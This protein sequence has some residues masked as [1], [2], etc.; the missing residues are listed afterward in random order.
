MTPEEPRGPGIRRAVHVPGGRIEREIDEEI[1]FHLE[2]RISA[3]IAGGSSPD[4]ARRIAESEYGDL[5]ASR[6]ELTTVDRHRR[7]RE[8]A[9]HWADSIA[10]DLRFA[11]RALRRS[12]AYAAT[13]VFTLV[14]GVAASVA[15]FAIVNSVLLRPLPFPDADRLIG[16]WHDM[17]PIGLM[18]ANQSPTTY[19]TYESQAHT[20]DGIGV[21]E[22]RAMNVADSRG[23][24]EPARL[25]AASCTASLFRV[26]GVPALHGRVIG[27]SDDVPGA[28]PVVLISEAAWH[29]RFGSDPAII[30]RAV[31]VNGV[32]REIVGVMPAAFRFPS[33]GVQLWIPLQFDRADPPPD[34]FSY[35]GVARLRLGVTLEQAQRD[36]TNV[37]PR[38]LDLFPNFV[39]G[40]TTRMMMDQTK[41]RPVLTH[42]Q[43]D[44]T[45]GVAGTLW[46]MAI[47]AFLLLLVACVNVANL[48]LV[49]ADAR[50]RELSVREALGA[51]RGRL[52]R[53]YFS[54]SAIV[55]AAGG[56]L[57]LGV[58]WVILRELVTHGPADLPRLAEIGLDARALAVAGAISVLAALTCAA[59]PM[60]RIGRRGG[61]VGLRE[62]RG[63]TA[64][65]SQHRLRGALVVAQ[66][67]LA[68][69]VLA[70]SG[71]L[72]RSLARLRAVRLGFD[73]E[74]VATVWVSPQPGRYPRGPALVHFYSTLVDDVARLPG[75][76]GV[77]VSSRLPLIVRGINQ[78]PLYPE[79]DPEY[80]TKLPPLQLFA[81]VSG[82]YFGVM[83]IPL[84][85]GHLFA[86]PDAQRE[87][88]AVV[89]KR[90]AE[91]FWHDSTGRAALGKRFRSLPAGPWYT[92]VGV[93]G[94]TRDTALAVPPSPAVY[95][96]EIVQKDT[97][98]PQTARTMALV[99]RTAGDPA[100]IEPALRQAVHSLDP[101]LP[102]FDGRPM[103]DALRSSMAR[104][105][106]VILVLG[107]GAVLTLL[108]GAV[109]LYGVMAYLVTLRR[110]ELGIRIALGATPRGIAAA[111]TGQGL[112]LAAG[113]VLGGLG[114]FAI[115]AR[116]ISVFLRVFLFGVRPWDPVALAGAALGLIAVAALASWIPGRRA[117]RVDPAEALRAD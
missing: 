67:A 57:G 13:A 16:T 63:G 96:P 25:D 104:L 34:A 111:T 109:G 50:Q 62:S 79:D 117:G 76:V 68:L 3:L 85:A 87:G 29:A 2:S 74:K 17:P 21:Y 22:E 81:S 33:A 93:V 42:L 39:P 101:T 45:G 27:A 82:D 99:V 19:F 49:R 92:V 65:R 35:N 8:R 88:D 73:P 24:V 107:G 10:Q 113:G 9:T 105:A 55:A 71:L 20:I 6:R 95:F 7:R 23:G 90:T 38:I 80:A 53:Y 70:S 12:P 1:A 26:L 32:R 37:L 44:V 4:E 40:I 64:S 41:P 91:I 11:A 48:T 78:T 108:L 43:D 60:W 51:G 115:A 77:G 83:R 100:S 58:A 5:R 56:A 46:M 69:V 75:V 36:F 14:I 18:H 52:I 114:L 97:V 30:G 59:I 89:S 15:I 106:F 28:P 86:G 103:T 98:T 116:F 84:L 47:A 102:A 66:I 94:D 31:D 61:A 72:L 112:A 54:E 110:R